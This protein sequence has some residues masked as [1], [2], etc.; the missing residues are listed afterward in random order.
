[1]RA[2]DHIIT[3]LEGIVTSNALWEK[4]T[5]PGPRA[6]DQADD[7]PAEEAPAGA[8][9]AED[10]ASSA[11][12]AFGTVQEETLQ[13]QR[14]RRQ[15]RGGGPTRRVQILT[16]LRSDP[17]RW[18]P[19]QELSTTIGEGHHRR[20]RGVLSEMVHDGEIIKRKE[21][22]GSP[23]SYQLAPASSSA[24]QEEKVMSG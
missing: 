11:E 1:M 18:W 23:A 15:G 10:L 7:A 16:L 9:Q 3:T 19:A 21:S 8:G 4:V 20:L 17:S 22:T 14:K 5:V 2:L 6:A 13:A 12:D 24:P